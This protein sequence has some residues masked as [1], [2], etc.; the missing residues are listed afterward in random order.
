MSAERWVYMKDGVLMLHQEN[1]GYTFMRRGAEAVD[2]P[3]TLEEVRQHYP[4]HY[5]EAKALLAYQQL[6]ID[7]EFQF[8]KLIDDSITSRYEGD[9]ERRE[10]PQTSDVTYRPLDHDSIRELLTMLWGD[11][12]S[13]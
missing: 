11:R 12:F 6:S 5:E 3:I 4:L 1:D 2:E 7:E 9:L 13:P 10:C 8:D